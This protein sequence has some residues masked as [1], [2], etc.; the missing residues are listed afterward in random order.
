MLPWAI[1]GWMLNVNDA[2]PTASSARIN[3]E[4]VFRNNLLSNCN[5]LFN[6]RDKTFET[7]FQ[8]S[9]CVQKKRKRGVAGDVAIEVDSNQARLFGKEKNAR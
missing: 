3:P 9:Y 2:I 8:R 6:E 1:A 4:A 5:C 7:K